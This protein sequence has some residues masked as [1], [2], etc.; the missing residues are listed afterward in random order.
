MTKEWHKGFGR[1][2]MMCTPVGNTKCHIRCNV[3]NAALLLEGSYQAPDIHAH[4]LIYEHI[5]DSDSAYHGDCCSIMLYVWIHD[6][7][8]L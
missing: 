7:N 1:C 2:T 4:L 6:L 8:F 5:P 3:F